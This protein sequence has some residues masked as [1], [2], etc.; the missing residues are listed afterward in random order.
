MVLDSFDARV[1]AVVTAMNQLNR[2]KHTDFTALSSSKSFDCLN[3]TI[4]SKRFEGGK[5]QFQF[6]PVWF[7]TDTHE[8]PIDWIT[9]YGDL[10]NEQKI[11][12]RFAAFLYGIWKDQ[13][14]FR[15]KLL[16]VLQKR[17]HW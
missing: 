1:T 17:L 14:A 2:H 15:T 5:Q 8:L 7:D 16:N 12:A 9:D 10:K 11:T 6:S 3:I 4:G 13:A